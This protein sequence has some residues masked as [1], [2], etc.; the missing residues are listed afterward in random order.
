MMAVTDNYANN[1]IN[2]NMWLL[3]WIW[4]CTL[5]GP[6]LAIFAM[7]L[8]ERSANIYKKKCYVERIVC[9]APFYRPYFKY[10]KT[11]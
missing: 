4:I 3:V 10:L 7:E 9:V 5:Q 11:G 6:F 8:G 2:V 1:S